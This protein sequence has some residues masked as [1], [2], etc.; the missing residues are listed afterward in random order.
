[1]Y[2]IM[3]CIFICVFNQAKYVDMFF[4]LLESLVIYGDLDDN[5]NILVYTST[6]FMNIIRQNHLFNDK[7]VFEI[8]DNYD[9]IEK[10]CKARLNLF[11]LQSINNYSK[12]LYLDTDILVKD[13]INK[14]FEVCEKDILYVLK[15]CL[16]KSNN[17]FYG[18]DSLFGDEINNYADTYGFTSGILL[19]NNCEKIK[20]LFILPESK[21]VY[22][23]DSHEIS[24][25]P[26][27]NIDYK[28]FYSDTLT[29]NKLGEFYR[30]IPLFAKKY[31]TKE[32]TP[33]GASFGFYIKSL[34][35][36]NKNKDSIKLKTL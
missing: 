10:A 7:I 36:S 22:S 4:L 28:F 18:C 33:E 8:N 27:F 6:P 32:Y 11:N 17:Q 24:Y 3:N 30:F 12:I 20:N 9:N 34:K 23:Y 31:D 1:M 15:E 26:Y 25:Y 21:S 35:I 16:L 29:L 5:T 13:D 14:V 2:L 19:F